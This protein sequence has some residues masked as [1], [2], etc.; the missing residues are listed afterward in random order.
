VSVID[1]TPE[2]F[3]WRAGG[4]PRLRV[5]LSGRIDGVALGEAAGWRQ[6][7]AERLHAAGLSTYDPT[8]VIRAATEGYRATPNEVYTNDRWNLARA[9][10]VL[11]NLELPPM[12]ASRDM[13]FFTIGEMFLAHAAGLPIIVFGG[14]A[15]E[16]RPGYEAIVTRS[17]PAQEPAID[18]IIHTYGHG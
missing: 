2:L 10:V 15:L 9:D 5:F 11:V 12:I 14:G 18:Y 8:R 17:F 13:P 3:P 4:R 16:G 6:R 7:A 1:P